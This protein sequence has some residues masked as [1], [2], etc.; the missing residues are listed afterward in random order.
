PILRLLPMVI[1]T[2]RRVALALWLAL[3][4]VAL[5]P[6]LAVDL[7]DARVHA[8]AVRAT[9]PREENSSGEAELVAYIESVARSIDARLETLDFA[10]YDHGHSFSRILEVTVPGTG[11]STAMIV[12]PLNHPEGV[13]PDEDRSASLAAALAVM[14]AAAREPI[15][16]TLR[17][18]FP[19]AE[20]GA[21]PGYPKGT[22]RFL[23]GYFAEEPHALLYLDASRIPL[24]METGADG[25]VAPS[26]LLRRT[27]E[28]AQT[29]RL[30]IEVHAG[31]N[32]LHRLGIS[33]AP[34]ALGQYLAK[35][36]PAVHLRS[37]EEGLQPPRVGDVAARLASFAGTWVNGFS[38]GVPDE[39]DRHYI[40]FRAG[41]RQ[42]VIGER[43]FIG[44]LL[45]LLMSTLAY[46]LVFHRQFIRYLRTIGRNSW[47]IPVLF[48]LIYAFLSAATYL[49]EL[50]LRARGFPT[51]WAYYPSAYFAFK[52][53]LSFFMF[54]IAA[55]LLRHLPLSKNGSFYSAAALF[56]LFLDIIIFSS[57]NLSFSYYFIWAFFW[58]FVFS[59]AR[60]RLLMS[61]SLA[62]A[63]IFLIR[64][65][66]DVLRIPELRVTE[67][68]LL[69]TRGDL[70]LSFMILPF[71]LMLI[72]LDFLIRHPVRGRRSFALRMAPMVSGVFVLGMVVF[73]IVSSPFSPSNPQPVTAVELVDY[74]NLERKLEISSPAPLGEMRI[75]FAG[76][77]FAESVTERDHTIVSQRLPDVL[78]VRLSYADFLD[79]DRARLEIDAPQPLEDVSIRFTSTQPMIL[80]DVSLP[81][82]ISADQ[83]SARVFVGKR[84]RL[85]LVIDFTVAR[86]TGPA[87]EIIAGSR[88]HPDPLEIVGSEID[89]ETHLLIRTRLEQ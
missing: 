23:E 7:D 34:P 57:L 65:A 28:A 10:D 18:L 63:P 42:L 44:F 35:D 40:Y 87:I 75:L 19:G 5:S 84:P 54:T 9:F 74:P 26:W 29:E 41:T 53:T 68:L 4:V 17:L 25:H 76:E 11:A 15:R 13:G 83:R 80:Y 70:L 52:I 24:V 48:L 55:L 64:V 32:Q 14:Q 22:R 88:A 43:A 62:L 47:N 27:V 72:R 89:V 36:I 39:W 69:S 33:S 82:S 85:P 38:A 58:A 67:E 12:V 6:A 37:G 16:P 50:S 21:G 1:N 56:V 20:H 86:G 77:E 30:P 59:V 71:L 46:S 45:G 51:I 78:S 2:M 49:L 61:V 3:I 8:E 66:V 81:F 73:V 79:R 31:I 60:S